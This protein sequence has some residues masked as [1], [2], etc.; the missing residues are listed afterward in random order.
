MVPLILLK[1]LKCGQPRPNFFM[2]AMF[3]LVKHSDELIIEGTTDGTGTWPKLFHAKIMA[4]ASVIHDL[5]DL[6]SRATPIG[7]GL[8]F[9][10]RNFYIGAT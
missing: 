8:A 10:F 6:Y 1:I 5:P 2:R 3:A 9:V 7:I 4:S